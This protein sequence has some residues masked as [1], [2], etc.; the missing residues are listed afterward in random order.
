MPVFHIFLTGKSEAEIRLEHIVLGKDSDFDEVLQTARKRRTFTEDLGKKPEEP[1][2]GE[3]EAAWHDEDD[4]ELVAVGEDKRYKRFRLS[5]EKY[6]SANV[7]AKRLRNDLEK[8]LP[9]PAWAERRPAGGIGAERKQDGPTNAL[10]TS[11]GAYIDRES[12]R[13]PLKNFSFKHL[14]NLNFE[15]PARLI[16]HAVEFHPTAQVAMV[17]SF[18]RTVTLF[19]VD[20][21]HNPKLTSV[22]FKEFPVSCAHFLNQGNEFL[23]S[24]KVRKVE[25]SLD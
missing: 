20:G 8:N 24:S 1:E 2:A 9:S 18:D 23:T 12:E 10:S 22:F 17:G 16:A 15:N 25:K 5:D 6:V 3:P 4:D 13:L 21:K 7:L 14:T 11:T 19:E